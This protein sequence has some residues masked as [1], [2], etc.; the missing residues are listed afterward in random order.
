MFENET[1]VNG[2]GEVVKTMAYDAAASIAEDLLS[3]IGKLED[4]YNEIL[5]GLFGPSTRVD[6]VAVLFPDDEWLWGFVRNLN[7]RKE[8]EHRNSAQDAVATSPLA[9]RYDV[10]YEFLFRTDETRPP[11]RIEAMKM[12]SGFSPLHAER[13]SRDLHQPLPA[14]IHA[15]F[16]CDDE[17]EYMVMSDVLSRNGWVAAQHCHSTYG[18]FSYFWKP[19]DADLWTS[20][21]FLKPRVNTR[22]AA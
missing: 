6:E 14:P 1:I 20:G 4:K 11:F 13:M 9:A 18:R 3:S 2:Y 5:R 19:G 21:C 15:S 7:S 8:W 17:D 10:Q 22:D 12:L 16:R